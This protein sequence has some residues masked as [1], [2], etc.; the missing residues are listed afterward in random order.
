[1]QLDHAFVIG[2]KHVLAGTP[3]QDYALSAELRPGLGLAVVSDGCGGAWAETDMGA[4][5]LA[6]AFR[7]AVAE[8]ATLE[9]AWLQQGFTD[10]LQAI[11]ESHQYTE[12]FMDYLA[13]VVGVVGTRDTAQAYFF[14]DG[15][16]ATV[17]QDG[18]VE[19]IE[20]HWPGNQP[21]Y[22]AYRQH[23]EAARH[24]M[25]LESL[26]AA[27]LM[28]QKSWLAVEGNTLQA[29]RGELSALP[30]AEVNNGVVLPLRPKQEGILG[31]A[32]LSDGILDM[33]GVPPGEALRALLA[34]KNFRG[35]FVTRRLIH[36]LKD[37][38]KEGKGPNDD[39]AMACL[40]FDD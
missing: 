17:H 24:G 13:T 23:A 39:L 3:C 34:F 40:W 36:A 35:G 7:K 30:Y 33:A 18:H 32:V 6:Y 12:N 14:G 28:L 11:F 15:A 19:L 37:W 27:S 26:K 4:R 31:I 5:A 10:R 21:F 29:T 1:M 20:V 16:L 25:Q 2:R 9:D 22:L 8:R 38:A